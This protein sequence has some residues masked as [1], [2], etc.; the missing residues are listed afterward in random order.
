[1][2]NVLIY[3]LSR[4]INKL[5]KSSLLLGLPWF[6]SNFNE[7]LNYKSN[8]KQ[9][10]F[11]QNNLGSYKHNK[12]YHHG[13]I[14]FYRFLV[15]RHCISKYSTLSL[16]LAYFLSW[17]WT[18]FQSEKR[19]LN[20][21]E[22]LRNLSYH[23]KLIFKENYFFLRLPCKKITL[24]V[25]IWKFLNQFFWRFF[26]LFFKLASFLKLQVFAKI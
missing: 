23:R 18:F 13:L 9:F 26:E 24:L 7:H 10:N 8:K 11:G 16:S 19:I 14:S 6:H 21:K 17:R 12:S 1:M 4:N 25:L 22:Y 2:R 20:C 15:G 5:H 3:L